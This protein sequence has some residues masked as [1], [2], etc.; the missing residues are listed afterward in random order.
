MPAGYNEDVGALDQ[1]GVDV[2][3]RQ[4]FGLC[5]EIRVREEHGACLLVRR[6]PVEARDDAVDGG[7]PRCLGGPR[8]G[9]VGEANPP[10]ALE[11]GAE[12]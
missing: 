9:L 7:R 10:A 12:E 3:D 5:L 6:S 11:E 4:R 1:V 8:E 2:L